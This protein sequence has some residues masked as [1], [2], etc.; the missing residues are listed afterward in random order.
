[1]LFGEEK[2]SE[3]CKAISTTLSPSFLLPC[4][5]CK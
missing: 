1:M 3:F 5:P 2:G 4:T